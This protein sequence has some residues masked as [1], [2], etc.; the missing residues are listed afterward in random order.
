MDTASVIALPISVRSGHR[1]NLLARVVARVLGN[2]ADPGAPLSAVLSDLIVLVDR[3]D[4]TL[5]T[6]HTSTDFFKSQIRRGEQ[7]FDPLDFFL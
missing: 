4:R 5:G 1:V 3:Y 2:G 7:K 6:L